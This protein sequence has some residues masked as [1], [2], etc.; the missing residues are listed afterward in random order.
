MKII[1]NESQLESI[2]LKKLLNE[3]IE[4]NSLFG[5]IEPKVISRPE[6]H[7]KRPLGN[8]QSDHAW[9]MKAP[10][11]TPVYSITKGKVSKVYESSGKKKSIYG[12][13]ISISGID[14]YPNIF[15]THLDSVDLQR[16]D[17]VNPGDYIG[18][19]TR[20]KSHPDSSH[21]HIGIDNK[22]DI[23]NYITK[24]GEIKDFDPNIEHSEYSGGKLEKGALIKQLGDLLKKHKGEA[25]PGSGIFDKIM[26]LILGIIGIPL[27]GQAKEGGGILDKLKSFGK[28]KEYDFKS[29]TDK[30]SP[31]KLL[32]DLESK[33][34]NENL[35][36]GLVANAKGESGFN[37][38]ARGDGGS[39]ANKDSENKKRNV[40]GYCSFGLWQYNICGGLGL[41]LLKYYGVDPDNASDEEKM[42]VLEDYDKQ[43]SFMVNHIK[44][45]GVANEEKSVKEWV[46]WIVYNVERPSDK[47]GAIAKRIKHA[48]E[49]GYA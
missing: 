45:K 35:A 3:D 8:W 21:V 30:V 40:G 23:Y 34:N 41:S 7:A 42:E 6:E 38:L 32:S 2:L 20:W 15:Y 26:L 39:Y 33:L 37:I 25:T 27:A 4:N 29:N 12:T 44:E 11:G 22:E 19:I 24:S 14:G 46:K 1:I 47:A 28:K 17:I 49:L 31:D 48:E 18:K 43:V 10:I 16:G 36:K 5:G 13:Q 9:D